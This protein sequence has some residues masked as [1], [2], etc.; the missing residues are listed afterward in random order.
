MSTV[1]ILTVSDSGF[2]GQR[3]DTSG[4]TIQEI[5]AAHG[6]QVLRREVVPDQAATITDRLRHWAEEADLVLTTGGTGL[7]PRDVTPEATWDVIERPVPGLTEAMRAETRQKTPMA[8]LSRGVAGVRGCCLIINLPG[9][10]QAVR[11]C[12]EVILPVLPHALETLKGPVSHH[13]TGASSERP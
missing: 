9:S 6:F 11:E 7:G 5:M 8:A 4:Q 1:G 12:L 3:E 10:P 13:P 2:Q